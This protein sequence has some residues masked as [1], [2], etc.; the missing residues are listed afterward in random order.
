MFD[1]LPTLTPTLS[2]FT[3]NSYFLYEKKLRVEVFVHYAYNCHLIIKTG[4]KFAHRSHD[5]K[6][7]ITYTKI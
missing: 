7:L 5:N 1:N 2:D 3:I 4:D 6:H